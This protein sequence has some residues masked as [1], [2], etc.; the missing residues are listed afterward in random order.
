M[1]APAELLKAAE[2]APSLKILLVLTI[3]GLLP[4]ILLT[5]TSF[6]RTVVVLSFVRQGV[7]AGQSPPTQVIMGLSMFLTMFTMSPVVE[8]IKTTAVDPYQAGKITDM[9]ALEV[10]SQPLKRFMLRQTRE[11][12]LKLFYDATNAPLP[13]TPDDVPMRLAMPAFVISELTTAF[14]MGVVILLPFL[15]VDLAVASLLMSMGMMMVPPS[16]IALPIKLLLFVLVD[17]WNLVA[18]SLLRSYT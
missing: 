17:G 2:L 15:V 11:A 10:G 14:Q 6:V 18:G 13:Q 7:G 16:T 8:Q 4:A 9:Q 3:L 12:D 1:N 5:T